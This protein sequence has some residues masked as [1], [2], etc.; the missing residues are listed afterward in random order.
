MHVIKPSCHRMNERARE[1]AALATAIALLRAY[2]GDRVRMSD[3]SLDVLQR[4]AERLR[5]EF[6]AMIAQTAQDGASERDP[7]ASA[8]VT[9][10]GHFVA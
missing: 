8:R 6:D 9:P 3:A 5:G 10:R 1:A 7:S 2:P 4:V